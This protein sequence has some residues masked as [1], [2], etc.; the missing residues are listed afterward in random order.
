MAGEG[1]FEF[2]H[3]FKAENWDWNEEILIEKKSFMSWKKHYIEW[4]ALS[5]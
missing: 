3:I 5:F 4:E 2:V 1:K